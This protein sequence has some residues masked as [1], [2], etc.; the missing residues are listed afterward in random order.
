MDHMIYGNV[1]HGVTWKQC[2]GIVGASPIRCYNENLAEYYRQKHLNESIIS[3]HYDTYTIG[4]RIEHP[5]YGVGIIEK[6]SGEGVCR[7][8]FIRFH[9]ND[10]KMLELGWV[11]RNCRQMSCVSE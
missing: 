1:G 7:C 8:V 9:K 10:C 3:E 4:D 6:I 11:D 5:R 2:C